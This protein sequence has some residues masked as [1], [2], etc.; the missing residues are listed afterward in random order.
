VV[1]VKAGSVVIYLADPLAY[2]QGVVREVLCNGRL[3]IDFE[4]DGEHY[5]DV[6]HPLEVELE[7]TWRKVAA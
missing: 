2:G 7:A 3:L 4:M 6:F 1:G 5:S